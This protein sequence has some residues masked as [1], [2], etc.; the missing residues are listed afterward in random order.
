MAHNGVCYD[1]PAL[2][3]LF[4]NRVFPPV[5]DTLLATRLIW[6][7]IRDLDFNALRAKKYP[8]SFTKQK[9][10]GTHKLEAWGYRLGLYK[11]DYCHEENAWEKWT[12]EMQSYCEQDVEVLYKLYVYIL[13]QEYSREA[14]ALEHEFQEVIFKQERCG[15]WFNKDEAVKLYGFMCAERN[16]LKQQLMEVFPPKRHEEIFIP[17]VNNRNRGYVKGEPFTKVKYIEFNPQSRQQIAERLKEEYD[18]HPSEFTDSGEPKLDGD[19]LA[20]LP[21]EPCKLLGKYLEIA[22]VIGMIAEGQ[23]AWLPLVTSQSRIHGRVITNGAVTGRCTHSNPNLAQIP[24]RGPY[25]HA[26]RALFGADPKKKGW[27]QVGCDASGLE[28]RMLSHYMAPY[29]GGAYVKVI[30]EGDIHTVNQKAA[31]LPTRND[32][33]TFVYAFM[34]GAG[35]AK[36]GSIVD[37]IASEAQ[38]SVIGKRLKSKFFKAIPAIKILI[39]NVK[40]ASKRKYLYGLD[41][42]KLHIRSSH[43][44]LNT[45]LQSAG[46]LVVKLATVIFHKEA[47]VR[48]GWKQGVDYDQVLHCHDEAQFHCHK[49]KAEQIGQLFAESLVLAG[50]HFGLR[51][52]TTGEYQIGTTWADTH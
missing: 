47:F 21:Y 25:G 39:D 23:K 5:F 36:L 14:L 10:V 32:A 34:Y 20:S 13:K 15:V 51:C 4:P 6:T 9:L 8:N 2:A 12:E 18:W 17:K 26:C 44:A 38:Q 35:D 27:V 33:K 50:K 11:G 46:A 22:K 52:P 45:L 49:D 40:T 42:R 3:K 16:E 7:N 41:R 37:P 48:Y 28:L 29:D 43:S 31:S 24:A 30:L 1:R 19:T